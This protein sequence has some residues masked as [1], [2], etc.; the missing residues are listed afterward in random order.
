MPHA[1][2]WVVQHLDLLSVAFH[3]PVSMPHA[4][5]W[6][7]Q[8]HRSQ[9]VWVLGRFQCRTR[10]CGWCSPAS[11]RSLPRGDCFNAARGF[12]GG[13]ASDVTLDEDL[14]RRFQCRTRLCGWC[15]TVRVAF[16]PCQIVRF[17]AARGFVGGAAEEVVNDD[18]Y[19][20]KFQCR[21]RLCGWCSSSPLLLLS[22]RLV[23]SMPHA[24][25][26]V[27]QL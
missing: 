1:A 15:S 14:I 11:R 21:T 5:L 19:E 7:V 25:L 20:L 6:V 9:L 22:P 4:A 24:A 12:V 16:C 26:W 17:N 2:L 23:V 8:L 18:Y 13:A 10:L 27:V 3:L